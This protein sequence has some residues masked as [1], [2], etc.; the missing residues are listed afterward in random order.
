M[1]PPWPTAR[2]CSRTR[3]R[4]PRAIGTTSSRTRRKRISGTASSNRSTRAEQAAV[5]AWEEAVSLPAGDAGRPVAGHLLHRAAGVHG[6]ALA[7]A[8]K[9]HRRLPPDLPRADVHRRD[10]AVPPPAR[11]LAGVCVPVDRADAGPGLPGGV[12]DRVPRGQVEE[13]VPAAVAPAVLRFLRH[14]DGG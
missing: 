14:Q 12:L 3:R 7:A 2:W 13:H 11:A 1:T 9:H 6:V 8:G 10:Q 4:W 5:A